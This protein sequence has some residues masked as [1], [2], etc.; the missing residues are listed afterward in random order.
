[1]TE[2]PISASV[3]VP[4]PYSCRFG[5]TGILITCGRSVSWF[6]WQR[7]DV[8]THCFSNT[9]SSFSFL[10]SAFF[11]IIEVAPINH[12][13]TLRMFRGCSCYQK[14]N[15][16]RFVAW[17]PHD[18]KTSKKITVQQQKETDRQTDRQ[19]DRDRDRQRQREGGREGEN[20]T[21]DL[22]PFLQIITNAF[23]LEY[24]T[25]MPHVPIQTDHINA[26]VC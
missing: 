18:L 12:S 25:Q 2:N 8:R 17:K 11:S 6:T 13:L 20:Q 10:L 19:S 9:M 1:M 3:E 14:L 5:P 22:A 16:T 15:V 4:S 24:A 21:T 23:S 26:R 7:S